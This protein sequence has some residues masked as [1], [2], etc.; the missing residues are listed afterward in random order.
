MKLAGAA[1]TN[2]TA[3]W[4]MPIFSQMPPLLLELWREQHP[5]GHEQTALDFKASFPAAKSASVQRLHRK[6]PRRRHPLKLWKTISSKADDDRDL[7]RLQLK[8]ALK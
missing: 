2:L 6:P 3:A 5:L 7:H 4:E 8:I 1:Q